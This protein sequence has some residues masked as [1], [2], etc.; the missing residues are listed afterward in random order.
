MQS[1]TFVWSVACIVSKQSGECDALTD[2]FSRYWLISDSYRESRIQ[3]MI[4][5]I[6]YLHPEVL[7]AAG[8]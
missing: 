7:V 6:E 5:Q 8:M 1:M 4:L 2:E 3:L